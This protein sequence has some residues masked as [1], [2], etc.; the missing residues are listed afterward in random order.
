MP[1]PSKEDGGTLKKSTHVY[2]TLAQD[3]AV[4]LD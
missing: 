1:H 4:A 3:D 2:P